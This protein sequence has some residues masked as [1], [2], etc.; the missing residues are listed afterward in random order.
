MLT[1]PDDPREADRKF[2]VLLPVFMLDMLS[3]S[4][5]RGR[6][7]V[8]GWKWKRGATGVCCSWCDFF[9]FYVY[10]GFIVSCLQE[11]SRRS[12]RFPVQSLLPNAPPTMTAAARINVHYY[13]FY[14]SDQE[15]GLAPPLHLPL[16]S[17]AADV[18]QPPWAGGA[19]SRGCTSLR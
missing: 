14:I 2:F 11:R 13:Y 17:L 10:R 5:Y 18:A 1:I 3:F 12:T 9:I 7:I 6:R 15:S 16:S 8:R 19:R 4:I